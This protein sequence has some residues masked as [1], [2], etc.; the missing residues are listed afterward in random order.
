MQAAFWQVGG[1]NWK[2]SLLIM[3]LKLWR[4]SKPCQK[5]QKIN[6]IDPWSPLPCTWSLKVFRPPV[7]SMENAKNKKKYEFS[8]DYGQNVF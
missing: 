8:F 1:I 7:E 2:F 5:R 6:K 3:D 4:R